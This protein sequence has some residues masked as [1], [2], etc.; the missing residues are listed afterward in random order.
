VNLALLLAAS[1]LWSASPAGA[2]ARATAAI[3]L[4]SLEMQAVTVTGIGSLSSLVM[5]NA[6]IAAASLIAWRPS[7]VATPAR[8]ATPSSPLASTALPWPAIAV[9]M[10]LALVLATRPLAGADPY[11]LER[12]SQILRLGT[13]AFDDTADI[14]VNVL[15]SSYELVLADVRQMPAIGA[16]LLR[17]H[18]V[19]GLAYFTLGVAAIRQ[20]LPGGRT[21][22]WS[23]PFLMPVVFHQ[24]AFVK[25]DLCSAT[26]A[27]VVLAWLATRAGAAPA[28]EVGAMAALT[29]LAVAMKWVAFPLGLIVIGMVA[30]QRRRD[31]GAW[32]AVISGGAVGAIAGGLVFT[33]AQTARWYGHPIEPL[34]ALGNRTSGA[35][36]ALESM[37]RFAISLF[38]FGLVTRGVW[39]GRGG[40]GATFGAPLIWALGVVVFAWRQPIVRRAA[41]MALVYGAIFAAIYPDA[42]VAHR[43]VL[44]P[45]VLLVAVAAQQTDGEGAGAVWARRALAAALA[46]SAVQIARSLWLYLSA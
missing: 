29:G 22:C 24:L 13:L 39:P 15:A 16:W 23:A 30:W 6:V 35:G 5:M 9:M 4:L 19:V 25:N 18:A 11:H 26:P 32:L 20:W 27:L 42:D 1:Q 33:L 46:V 2:F 28:R 8:S 43:L 3:A 36:A 37:A 10:A 45:G 44:A 34:A 41:A 21:W 7:R 31:A 17:L 14:K 38:D 40:W 12:V